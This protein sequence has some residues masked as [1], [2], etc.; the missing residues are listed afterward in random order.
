MAVAKLIGKADE[1]EL[2]FTHNEVTGLWEAVVPYANDGI[3]IVDLLAVDEVGNESHYI[4]ALFTVD[5]TNIHC[6]LRLQVMSCRLLNKKPYGMKLRR[7][8][9][10]T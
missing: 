8:D 4:K 7:C 2:V 3:Y 5:T 10:V 9:C 1:F 6:K